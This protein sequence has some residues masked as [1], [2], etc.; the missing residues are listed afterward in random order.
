MAEHK[1]SYVTSQR[2][3]TPIDI[4]CS[5]GIEPIPA[6]NGKDALEM[7]RVHIAAEKVKISSVPRPVF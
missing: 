2:K 4:V 5:C 1:I 3:E 7:A 6:R